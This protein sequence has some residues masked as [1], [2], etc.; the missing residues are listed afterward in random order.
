LNTETETK[1]LKKLAE[2]EKE[3]G[4]LP[5]PLRLFRDLLRVQS[6]AKRQ[7]EAPL[8]EGPDARTVRERLERGAPAL[9]IDD[10]DPAIPLLT[11]FFA[12]IREVFCGYPDLF[13]DLAAGPAGPINGQSLTGEAVRAWFSGG[14]MPASAPDGCGEETYRAMVHFT[15]KPLLEACAERLASLID[16][17]KWRGRGCPVCGGIPDMAYLDKER[18]GRWLVCSRCDF[19]WLFPRLQCPFC[20]T[21]DQNALAFLTDEKGLYRLHV[22]ER[23]QCYLKTIDLRQ[24]D[25]EVLLPLERLLTAD[26]DRQA[27]EEGYRLPGGPA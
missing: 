1:I 24:T 17:E 11:P 22:C 9:D 8:P 14:P 18:G 26:M 2:L 4:S 13:A 10:L 6:E 12:M 20:G 19:A 25:D 7:I 16:A 15:L 27:R 5:L 21:E 23:C 3:G